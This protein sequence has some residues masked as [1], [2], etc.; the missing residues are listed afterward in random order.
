MSKQVKMPYRS[1]ELREY[2]TLRELTLSAGGNGI[3]FTPS[4]QS[5][6]QHQSVSTC[7]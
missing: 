4:C 6:P 2:G 5:N 7:P 1:P 3:D